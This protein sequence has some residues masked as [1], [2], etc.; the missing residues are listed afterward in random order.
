LRGSAGEGS[1]SEESGEKH[2]AFRV[3]VV[4]KKGMSGSGHRVGTLLLWRR[5]AG[6]FLG[7]GWCWYP[8]TECIDCEWQLE[9][10]VHVLEPIIALG[11]FYSCPR[12][13][14]GL[15]FGGSRYRCTWP[16]GKFVGH[17]AE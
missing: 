1:E 12:D 6:R 11:Y 13:V 17:R 5:D 14:L 7:C 9:L 15:L 3:R 16:A 10:I 4:P 2:R 8:T